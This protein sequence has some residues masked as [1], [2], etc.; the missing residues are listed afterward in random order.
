[1][2]SSW[3][4]IRLSTC[5]RDGREFYRR[6]RELG[7]T[8]PVLILSAY[9]ALQAQLE[10]GAEAAS[11]KPFDPQDLAATVRGLVI[12]ESEQAGG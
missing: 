4:T 12:P 2:S 1:M 11:S 8:G 5:L 6:A 3:T 7:Y 10:L 9:G